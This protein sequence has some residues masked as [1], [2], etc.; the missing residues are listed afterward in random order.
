MN[1][2]RIQRRQAVVTAP[3]EGAFVRSVECM[4]G[5]RVTPSCGL[6]STD[7]MMRGLFLMRIWID[8]VWASIGDI[9][10]GS[11]G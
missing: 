8:E 6:A 2:L 5:I 9:L 3:L 11:R 10:Q 7:E 4:A 1:K